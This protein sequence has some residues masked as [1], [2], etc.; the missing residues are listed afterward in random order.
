MQPQRREISEIQ[1]IPEPVE[2][3]HASPAH[4][5][6]TRTVWFRRLASRTFRMCQRLGVNITPKHFYWPIPDLEALAGKDWT[7]SALS[8]A[9][10]L[11]LPRQVQFLEQNLLRFAHEWNFP[12]SPS[13][14]AERFHFNNGYFERVDAEIAYS[15]VR[16][17]QPAKIIE[18]GSGNT[19]KLL[20]EALSRNEQEGHPGELISI[21][22]HPMPILTRGFHG[23]SRLIAEP[24]QN[25]PLDLF[26]SLD[27]H[28]ILFLDSSHV[29]SLGSDVVHEFLHILPLLKSGV[30]IHLHDIFM[31]YDYPEKFVMTNLCFWAEQYLLEAFLAY[32]RD[33][34]VLWSSSAMQLF[35]RD[36]L[37]RQFPAWIDSYKRMPP[38]I[39]VFSPTLDGKNVWPCSFWMQK[40]TV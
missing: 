11:G 6:F 34:T 2:A 19:T 26:Q 18:V 7:A 28:D 22:P 20:A 24:V 31:P 38:S 29:V 9:V 16:H 33:F 39:Q 12:E 14:E 10:D 23:L 27:R 25:V 40:T 4:E 21:E 17:F 30:V 5:S 8:S 36:T 1:R 13:R 3:T 35:H 32:N 37:E 15:I